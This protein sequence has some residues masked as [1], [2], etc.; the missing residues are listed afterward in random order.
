MGVQLVALDGDEGEIEDPDLT[1]AMAT[2]EAS[3][4]KKSKVELRCPTVKVSTLRPE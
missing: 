1:A 3:E 2:I 4:S